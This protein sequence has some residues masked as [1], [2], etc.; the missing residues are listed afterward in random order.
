VYIGFTIALIYYAT[1][2]PGQTFSTHDMRDAGKLAVPVSVVG[3][4]MDVVVLVIP[5]VAISRLQTST[6][7]KVGAMLIFLSGL[8]CVSIR[9]PS[10]DTC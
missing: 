4:V 1:P 3:F 10:E 2:R 6:G 8:L 7:K 5:I 9:A